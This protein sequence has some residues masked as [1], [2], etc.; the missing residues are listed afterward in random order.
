M[1]I[2]IVNHC[3]SHYI[4]LQSA[5]DDFE[6]DAHEGIMIKDLYGS[7]GL[8]KNNKTIDI[9]VDCRR[10]V[11]RYALVAFYYSTGGTN[12]WYSHGGWLTHSSPPM[13]DICDFW[14]CVGCTTVS[15]I[16]SDSLTNSNSV[17]N[18]DDDGF[19][20]VL[21]GMGLFRS[22]RTETW[23]IISIIHTHF[24]GRIGRP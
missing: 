21:T 18:D 2:H 11:E 19:Q 24:A 13:G 5:A 12:Q 9:D 14:L 20:L 23:L 1:M 16:R 4:H 15:I 6:Y 8:S 22:I 17:K 3:L 7:L 10:N